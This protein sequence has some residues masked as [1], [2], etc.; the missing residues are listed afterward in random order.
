MNHSTDSKI[1]G[2]RVFVS[3]REKARGVE[4]RLFPAL[5]HECLD[6]PNEDVWAAWPYGQ[7][8]S[9]LQAT[10]ACSAVPETRL[11]PRNERRSVG[12]AAVAGCR[13]VFTN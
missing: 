2:S 8:R 3:L 5:A 7:L 12:T 9:L 6:D 13:N 1:W 4:T 11:P 10:R